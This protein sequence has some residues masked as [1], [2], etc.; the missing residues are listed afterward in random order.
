MSDRTAIGSM[1]LYT[2]LDRVERGLAALGIGP[3]DA[4]QPEQLF[5]IDQWHYRGTDAIRVAAVALGLGP[6]SRVL[7][8]GSGIGGPPPHL[9][10]TPRCPVTALELP[11]G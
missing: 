4:I 8:I 1:P 6:T 2:N 7:D 11:P 3:G 5:A 9:P 10:P